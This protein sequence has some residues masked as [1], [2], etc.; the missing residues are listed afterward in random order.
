MEQ[1]GRIAA[2]HA[3]MQYTL[4]FIIWDLCEL[5]SDRGAIVTGELSTRALINAVVK[6]SDRVCPERTFAEQFEKELWQAENTRNQYLHSQWLFRF[7]PENVALELLNEAWGLTKGDAVRQKY[8][9]NSGRIRSEPVTVAD[10]EQAAQNLTS[11]VGRLMRWF[12][13]GMTEAEKR[14]RFRANLRALIEERNAENLEVTHLAA[15]PPSRTRPPR[16]T[17]RPRRGGAP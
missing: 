4:E 3:N 8:A 13:Q 14:H 12:L 7:N 11:L 1:L 17:R 9:R 16:R 6:L 5:D 10:L 15:P 2:A